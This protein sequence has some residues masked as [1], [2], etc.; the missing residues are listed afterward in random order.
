MERTYTP[1]E[2]ANMIQAYEQ[3]K[4]KHSQA[5]K[6]YYERNADARRAYAATYY[7]KKKARL[8]TPAEEPA[9]N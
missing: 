2:M 4:Q 9:T 1:V 8:A 7:A 6:R 3:H 5:Q